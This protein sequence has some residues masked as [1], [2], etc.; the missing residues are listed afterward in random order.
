MKQFNS[1]IQ[2]FSASIH[3]PNSWPWVLSRFGFEVFT[4]PQ[5]QPRTVPGPPLGTVCRFPVS[6]P[7]ASSSRRS[8]RSASFEV[9]RLPEVAQ[10]HFVI[11]SQH[12][13]PL[14]PALHKLK[15]MQNVA[16]QEPLMFSCVVALPSP[17]WALPAT[18]TP[19][20]YPKQNDCREV[21]RTI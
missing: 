20:A 6:Y 3:V 8:I 15:L 7:L 14:S 12:A 13:Q 4:H 18:Q 21:S 11:S 10:E 17:I 2:P 16:H 1:A 9:S 5:Q 19:R